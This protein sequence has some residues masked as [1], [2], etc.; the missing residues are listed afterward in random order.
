V[1]LEEMVSE[2]SLLY[3]D[4]LKDEYIS[5]SLYITTLT[6]DE[7]QVDPNRCGMVGSPTKV[8]KVESVVLGGSEHIKIEPTKEGMSQLI[9]KLMED[10][11]FG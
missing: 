3:I 9:D 4:D 7:L 11:I 8:Y 10:R 5:K 2:N 6:M 1:E